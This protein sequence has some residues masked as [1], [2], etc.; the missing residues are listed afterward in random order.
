M[1]ASW[2]P[3]KTAELDPSRSPACFVVPS[4]C[5][6]LLLGSRVKR[7]LGSLCIFVVVVTAAW[8]YTV[9]AK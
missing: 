4:L 2:G 7:I 9:I 5:K 8:E 3:N 1:S 6:L